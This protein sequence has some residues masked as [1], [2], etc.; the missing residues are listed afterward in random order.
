MVIPRR[1]GERTSPPCARTGQA[2]DKV[3]KEELDLLTKLRDGMV[4]TRSCSLDVHNTGRLHRA[5]LRRLRQSVRLCVG[6]RYRRG[7]KN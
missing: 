1:K 2:T 5:L 7:I 4:R 3:T 6:R